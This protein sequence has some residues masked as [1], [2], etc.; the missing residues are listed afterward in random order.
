MCVSVSVSV[1]KCECQCEGVH[2][3]VVQVLFAGQSAV[4]RYS[5]RLKT[6]KIPTDIRKENRHAI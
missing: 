1:C 4:T 2:I 3:L 5:F 6:A